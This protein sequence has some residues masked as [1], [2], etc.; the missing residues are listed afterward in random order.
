MIETREQVAED[1]RKLEAKS[2]QRNVTRRITVQP[3]LKTINERT[4]TLHYQ[5][6]QIIFLHMLLTCVMKWT[7]LREIT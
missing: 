6:K 2:L 7:F 5:L 4:L 1:M 3:Y